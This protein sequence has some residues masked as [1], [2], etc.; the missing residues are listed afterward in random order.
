MSNQEEVQKTMKEVN[1]LINEAIIK[2]NSLELPEY[3]VGYIDDFDG[4]DIALRT[5]DGGLKSQW[6]VEKDEK[7]LFKAS[8]LRDVLEQITKN[9]SVIEYQRSYYDSSC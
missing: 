7:E 9:D 8:V 1:D 3:E 2:L 5:K 6:Y 4:Y